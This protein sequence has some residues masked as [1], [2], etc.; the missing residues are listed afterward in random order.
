MGVMTDG[1]KP[2]YVDLNKIEREWI[3]AADPEEDMCE[4]EILDLH[5][6]A[7]HVDGRQITEREQE[8]YNALT[9]AI[10]DYNIHFAYRMCPHCHYDLMGRNHDLWSFCP[11]CGQRLDVDGDM[12]DKDVLNHLQETGSE[13]ALE[14]SKGFRVL[15]A[16]YARGGSAIQNTLKKD[17]G[18]TNTGTMIDRVGELEEA[19]WVYVDKQDTFPFRK[20]IMLTDDGKGVAKFLYEMMRL[21]M[22]RESSR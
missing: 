20:R 7:T 18:A 8:A 10:I 15:V 6:Q 16:L 1:K 17:V 3:P 19:G 21:L 5:D 2:V 22:Y 14:H 12:P 4:H 11:R 9:D 13:E